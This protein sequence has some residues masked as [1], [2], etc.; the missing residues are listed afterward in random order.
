MVASHPDVAWAIPISLGDSHRGF[1]VVGTSTGYFEHFRYGRKR[2]LAFETGRPFEALYEAVLGADVARTLGYAIGDEITVAHGIG[3]V[4]FVN[5]AE[6]PFRVT[7]RCTSASRRSAQF[8]HPG[9]PAGRTG[10]QPG[11]RRHPR[12]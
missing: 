3:E 1:R 11:R 6:H 10:L 5:H 4:S 2:S 12:V 8:T 7:G 9:S